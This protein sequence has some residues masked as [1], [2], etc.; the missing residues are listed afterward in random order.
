MDRALVKHIRS[1]QSAY[2]ENILEAME[3]FVYQKER[4]KVDYTLAVGATLADVDLKSFS[5]MIRKTDSFVVLD[6]NIC[7][8]I[9]GFNL[10]EQGIKAASNML[11]K[12][13]MQFFASEIY[14]G[15]INSQDESNPKQQVRKLFETL[16][17][18]ILNG[19]SNIPLDF[20]QVESDKIL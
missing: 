11:S 16:C 6:E 14:L 18:G 20:E 4:Y 9:F 17:Y 12:Y 3:S 1:H 7:V 13:E 19:M 5:G 15:I 10:P 8:I 2:E